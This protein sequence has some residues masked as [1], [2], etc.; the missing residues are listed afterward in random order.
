MPA[1]SLD[2]APRRFPPPLHG[3]IDAPLPFRLLEEDDE[4]RGFGSVLEPRYIVRAG[5]LDQ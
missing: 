2:L 4:I 3:K 1:F 5:S